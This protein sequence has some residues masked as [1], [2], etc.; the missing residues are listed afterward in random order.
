MSNIYILD[1]YSHMV[2][3][4]PFNALK[5]LIQHMPY[6]HLVKGVFAFITNFLM[7]TQAMRPQIMWF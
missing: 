6:I 5:I 3:S 4:S 7:Y 1:S 2:L